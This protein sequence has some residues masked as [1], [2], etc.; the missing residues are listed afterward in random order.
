MLKRRAP[1]HTA[2]PS[3]RKDP[4]VSEPYVRNERGGTARRVLVVPVA[5]ALAALLAVTLLSTRGRDGGA[6]EQIADAALPAALSA[7]QSAAVAEPAAVDPS[8]AVDA[9]AAVVGPAGA[10]CDEA[11]LRAAITESE[12]VNPDMVYEVAYLRCA[13]GF[14]W[15][16]IT[17]E[18]EGATI[19]LRLSETGMTL[20]D[21]GSGIC[22]ADSEIPADV[23]PQIAPPRPDPARDCDAQ[24]ATPIETDAH[25]TG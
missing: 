18:G 19:F 25:F 17:S 2:D 5:I 7:A 11:T 1:I 23:V 9:P 14:G 21:L 15:A 20:L 6:H 13:E 8:A 3:G 24:G 4:D 10:E 16:I 12:A 22:V